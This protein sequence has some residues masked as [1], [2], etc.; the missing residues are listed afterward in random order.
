[1]PSTPHRAAG[2]I[3]PSLARWCPSGLPD[4][5]EKF[6]QPAF[7]WKK[8]IVDQ[9]LDVILQSRRQRN[10]APAKRGRQRTG[11]GILE[12]IFGLFICHGNPTSIIEFIA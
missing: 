12:H 3:S 8:L 9:L 1:M 10:F 5:S 11:S 7:P 2:S 4:G 6:S